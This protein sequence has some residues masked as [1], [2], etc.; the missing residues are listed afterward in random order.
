MD[1]KEREKL[2]TDAVAEF[3]AGLRS[4]AAQFEA[5]RAKRKLT[6]SVI[7]TLWGETRKLSDEILKRVYTGLT[8]AG[9]EKPVQ[10]KN[11]AWGSGNKRSEQGETGTAD[12]DHPGSLE[13]KAERLEGTAGRE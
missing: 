3:E 9:E 8:N 12:T 1:T 10:E 13:P 2:I 6:A 4:K 5:A 7:E 11:S